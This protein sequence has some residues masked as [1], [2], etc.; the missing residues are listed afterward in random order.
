MSKVNVFSIILIY[1]VI[2]YTLTINKNILNLEYILSVLY[3]NNYKILVI[4]KLL[5]SYE[6]MH[7]QRKKLSWY[8]YEKKMTDNKYFFRFMNL[9][10]L[11]MT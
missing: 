1:D 7:L 2:S 5:L 6:I 10:I 4:L 3:E 9:K 8:L 11:F